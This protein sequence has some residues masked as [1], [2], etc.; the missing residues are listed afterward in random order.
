MKPLNLL[1]VIIALPYSVSLKAQFIF[2]TNTADTIYTNAQISSVTIEGQVFA[3]PL[4]NDLTT[5]YSKY[6]VIEID[7]EHLGVITFSHQ[8]RETYLPRDVR[9]VSGSVVKF[10]SKKFLYDLKNGYSEE[11]SLNGLPKEIEVWNSSPVDSC[12]YSK[13]SWEELQGRIA[14]ETRVARIAQEKL[15]A[16]QQKQHLFDSITQ[17]DSLIGSYDVVINTRNSISV[18]DLGIVATI[19]LTEN[20]ITLKNFDPSYPILRCAFDM[21]GTI[22]FKSKPGTF[23][24]RPLKTIYDQGTFILGTESGALTLAYG[25]HMYTTTFLIP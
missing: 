20:G 24:L 9:I 11:E 4:L 13:T 1:I 6:A 18:K 10:K 15:E 8:I 21:E 5:K 17:L 14:E 3:G 12:W 16:E 23:A 19:I 7:P 22:A 2:N 25:K